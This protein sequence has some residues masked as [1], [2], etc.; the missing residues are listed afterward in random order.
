MEKN[1]GLR[2]KMKH[3]SM[4]A[5]ATKGSLCTVRFASFVYEQLK[6][7]P[8]M[9]DSAGWQR[10]ICWFSSLQNSTFFELRLSAFLRWDQTLSFSNEV[11]PGLR[12]KAKALHDQAK[13]SA[14]LTSQDLPE[15]SLPTSS[16]CHSSRVRIR[17]FF[18]IPSSLIINQIM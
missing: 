7:F 12:S 1:G 14:I 13:D 8:Q 10:K 5:K 18:N 11:F 2:H 17:F 6:C 4:V 9:V 16:C 3:M 15:D